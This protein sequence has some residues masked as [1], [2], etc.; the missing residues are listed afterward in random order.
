M[1]ANKT[2]K[3]DEPPSDPDAPDSEPKDGEDSN[4][5]S[6]MRELLKRRKAERY[7]EDEE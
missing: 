6:R 5:G 2:K 4:Y 3:D 7:E 1:A